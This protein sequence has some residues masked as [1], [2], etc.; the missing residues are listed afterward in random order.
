L[1][2]NLGI[3]PNTATLPKNSVDLAPVDSRPSCKRFEK[4]R[5]TPAKFATRHRRDVDPA[6]P[7]SAE[8]S[9]DRHGFVDKLLD[10]H[11]I[12]CAKLPC[13]TTANY[14]SSFDP[15]QTQGLFNRSQ[16]T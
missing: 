3:R 6:L 14:L 5:P 8:K 4:K 15:V 16:S 12:E 1:V 10:I 7:P 13:S 11:R 9:L 2:V